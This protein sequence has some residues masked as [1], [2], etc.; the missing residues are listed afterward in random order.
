MTNTARVNVIDL[1]SSQEVD[2]LCEIVR[3]D[4]TKGIGKI[5]AA[6]K[7]K[8]PKS[9]I[10]KRL[11]EELKID[12]MEVVGNA[13]S[14]AKEIRAAAKRTREDPETTEFLPIGKHTLAQD[15]VPYVTVSVAGVEHEIL[16]IAV[17]LKAEFE[18]VELAIINGHIKYLTGDKCTLSGGAKYK[19]LKLYDTPEVK[20]IKLPGEFWFAGNGINIL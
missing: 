5:A 4:G 7:L 1:L 8:M 15:I 20:E 11:N 3:E 10:S 19:S 14:D 13:W 17:T 6:S 9:W 16:E 12:A 18:A 2:E